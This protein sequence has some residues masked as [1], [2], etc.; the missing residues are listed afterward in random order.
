MQNGAIALLNS[1]VING[2]DGMEIMSELLGADDGI[3]QYAKETVFNK[4]KRHRLYKK[5]VS[6]LVTI[7]VCCIVYFIQVG[8]PVC[9]ALSI[10]ISII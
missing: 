9:V 3:F 4:A 8:L 7:C 5:G 2:I 10:V 6:G 1:L